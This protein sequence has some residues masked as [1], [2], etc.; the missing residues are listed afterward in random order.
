MTTS[1]VEAPPRAYARAAGVLYLIIIVCAGF[2]E[3]FVRAGLVVPGDA[4]TTAANIRASEWLFR[5]GFA[6]DLVA[7]LSDVALAVLF[8]V[9][10]RPVSRPLALIAG[11]FRLAQATVLGLNMLHHFVALLILGGAAY[12]T[13]FEPKQLDALALLSMDAHRHGY[14]IGQMFF[15]IHCLIIGYLMGRAWYFPR[16]LG[17]LMVVAGLG[18]LADGFGFFLIP[19]A[20]P[21]LSPFF[22]APVVVAELALCLWLLAKGV[23][24]G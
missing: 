5:V 4:A 22:I 10:L 3:G 14:L 2:A 6:T 24:A 15:G 17:I 21:A 7:F 12:L 19:A 11:A 1:T 8:Y 23:R 16:P 9:L 13:V 20:A 18:Y